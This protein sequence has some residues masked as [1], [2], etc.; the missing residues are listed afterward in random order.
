MG[1][2]LVVF[3]HTVYVNKIVIRAHSQV[4]STRRILHL[5]KD[6]LPVLNVSNLCKCTIIKIM[7]QIYQNTVWPLH[8]GHWISVQYLIEH[9]L[10][11]HRSQLSIH[12]A[13]AIY[14]SEGWQRELCPSQTYTTITDTKNKLYT[15]KHRQSMGLLQKTV[16]CK[17]IETNNFVQYPNRAVTT[18]TALIE[19]S[20]FLSSIILTT[21]LSQI[22]QLSKVHALQS[23]HL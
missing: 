9:T 13:I 6:F 1:H 23:I 17:E 12:P 3:C 14:R 10:F 5:M 8:K 7:N 4:L 20:P 19:Q 21:S 16:R 2:S 15:L 11:Q 22:G 18:G